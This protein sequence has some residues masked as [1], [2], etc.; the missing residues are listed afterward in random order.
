MAPRRCPTL[1]AGRDTND[2]T[3][4]DTNDWTFRDTND[5]T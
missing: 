5:W 2:W 4:R 3:F 1:T